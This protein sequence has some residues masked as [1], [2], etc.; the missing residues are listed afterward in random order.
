MRRFIRAQSRPEVYLT[1]AGCLGKVHVA[2]EDRLRDFGYA[3][4]ASGVPLLDPPSGGKF[5]VI[6]GE[7]VWVVG[8]DFAANIPTIG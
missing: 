4:R 6:A 3:I 1:D 5:E 7:K 8:D 2:S